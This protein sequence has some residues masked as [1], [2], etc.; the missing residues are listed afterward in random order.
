MGTEAFKGTGYEFNAAADKLVTC[1]LVFLSG[2]GHPQ[3]VSDS[4][5][6]QAK[7]T[8]D[9]LTRM[10]Q[11]E[12]TQ[13]VG[14]GNGGGAGQTS[15]TVSYVLDRANNRL[16]RASTLPGVAP[17]ADYGPYN[18]RDQLAGD[19]YDANG[20]TLVSPGVTTG[21]VYDWADRLTGRDDGR[22]SLAYDGDG[23][24][25]AKSVRDPAT[26]QVET[27]RYLIDE[28]N[29]TGHAQTVEELD[30]AGAVRAVHVWGRELISM[31]RGI[32][33]TGDAATAT[34]S[35]PPSSP[36]C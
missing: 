3:T 7:Y 1:P 25:V 24:R 30:G 22:I 15:G 6:P 33:A 19:V 2:M 21:D 23:N 8:Y 18:A 12:L 17:V 28:L 36:E 13:G 32:G 20:N 29:P 10:T 11:E 14:D 27:T 26:G 9:A 34:A 5:G 31:R 16:S 35:T 4:Q